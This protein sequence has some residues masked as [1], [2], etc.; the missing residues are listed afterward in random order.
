[1]SDKK[2]VGD[3]VGFV[4]YDEKSNRL[5]TCLSSRRVAMADL[6]SLRDYPDGKGYRI[7]KVV[8]GK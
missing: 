4:V 8:L 5:Q 6:K 7:A 1:M 2:K 3:V